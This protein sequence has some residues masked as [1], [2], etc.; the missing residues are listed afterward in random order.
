MLSIIPRIF[1]LVAGLLLAVPAARSAPAALPVPAPAFVEDEVASKQALRQLSDYILAEKK[2]FPIIF[3]GGYY[4]RTLVAASRILGEPRYLEAAIDYADKLLAKQSP[5]GYWGTGYGDIFLAD[6]GSALGL[7]IVLHKHVDAGRQ[8]K[9]QAAIARFVQAIEQ[10]GLV[11]RSGAFGVGYR[12]TPQGEV[13]GIMAEEY[14]ISSALSGGEIFTWYG[15]QT[16]DPHYQEVAYRAL[17]WVIS[18]MRTDGVIPYILPAIGADRAMMGTPKA[19][20]K[21]WQDMSYQVATYLGEG[22]ISF[23]RHATWPAWKDEIRQAIRPHIEFLLRSQNGDGTWAKPDSYDQ[24]R[25]PGVAN[26]L[27]WY[28]LNVERDE[29]IPPA[30]RKF[31]RVLVDPAAGKEFGLMNR[32]AV[33]TWTTPANK[34]G[35]F[36]PNDIVTAIAGRALVEMLAPGI[37]SEW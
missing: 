36:V 19:D 34:T 27:M 21:L 33:T 9:Y 11:N 31:N 37:D 16:V 13:T 17:R 25:S 22:I 29:R 12:A 18:T 24:K 1:F 30:V 8:Q 26:F 4:M 10:D 23:D 6:T 7:F 20:A 28:Y 2:D 35:N 14:T 15:R 32:G 5:R 3:I